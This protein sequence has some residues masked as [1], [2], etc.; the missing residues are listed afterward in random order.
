MEKKYGKKCTRKKYGKKLWEKSSGKK[1][2]EKRTEKQV[3]EKQYGKT[4]R[5][6]PTSVAHPREPPF[7][8]TSLPVVL[9]VMRNET[10]C[11]T[12]LLL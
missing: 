5:K 7:G 3:R 9:S 11:T 6:T 8:D 12:V 10:F 4:W 1:V 2:R